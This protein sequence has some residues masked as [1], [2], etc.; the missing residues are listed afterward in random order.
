MAKEPEWIRAKVER[1]IFSNSVQKESLAK[2]STNEVFSV[3]ASIPS[4]EK[5]PIVIR[6]LFL[7]IGL[8]MLLA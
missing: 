4:S 7:L 8:K 1:D 6:I 5:Q 3:T 2:Y